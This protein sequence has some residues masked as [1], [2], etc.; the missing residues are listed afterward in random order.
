M[1]GHDIAQGILLWA[2]NHEHA[3]VAAGDDSSVASK[4][5][6]EAKQTK[7]LIAWLEESEEEDDESG[8]EEESD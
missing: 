5:V 1:R 3:T 7:D 4:R 2:S 6:F 8:E